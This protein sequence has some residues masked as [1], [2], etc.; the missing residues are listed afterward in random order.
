MGERPGTAPG[1]ETGK[2]LQSDWGS[3][4]P[5][6]A[7]ISCS[8]LSLDIIVLTSNSSGPNFSVVGVEDDLPSTVSASLRRHDWDCRAFH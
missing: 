6:V 2:T 3:L 8:L 1:E 5:G 7:A 4:L